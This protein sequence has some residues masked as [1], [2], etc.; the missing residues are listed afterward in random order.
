ML[1]VFGSANM[2]LLM[3]VDRL[4]QVGETVL[5]NDYS[6]KPGGKGANQAVAAARAGATVS[7]CGALGSDSFG[8]QIIENFLTQ[9]VS[10]RF[11]ARVNAPTGLALVGIDQ[12]AQNQIIVASGANN[13]VQ[14]TQLHGG[15]AG[16]SMLVCQLEIPVAEVHAA[17]TD[18]KAH[19][20]TTLLNCAPMKTLPSDI[21]SDV[22]ILCVNEVELR[23]IA[24]VFK[25]DITENDHKLSKNLSKSTGCRVL[26]TMGKAGALFVDGEKALKQA[27]L[28]VPVVDST[29]A[30]DAFVGVF[31]SCYHQGLSIALK[32]ASVAAGLACTKV[33]AQ[34]ALPTIAEIDQH[35]MQCADP[36]CVDIG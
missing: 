21:F 11:I 26:T 27:I 30:G 19:G 15:W 31:A 35:M 29:G 33:G 24:H 13:H 14:A 8:D 1:M 12:E 17:L 7:F 25:L 18:A 2:D 20:V 3:N 6:Q 22:D 9:G 34:S 23:Q 16:V 10:T 5:C 32:R 36:V 28:D 4:P